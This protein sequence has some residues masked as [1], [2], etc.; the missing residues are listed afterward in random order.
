MMQ[1]AKISVVLTFLFVIMALLTLYIWNEVLPGVESGEDV[2]SNSA[3]TT[4]Q[5]V[6]TGLALVVVGLWA[7]YFYL[8]AHSRYL[9]HRAALARSE[10]YR[11]LRDGIE[12]G[13]DVTHLA[14]G[15][16]MNHLP[17]T[18]RKSFE[19]IASDLRHG[20]A[21]AS[22]LGKC[23]SI[24]PRSDVA[25]LKAAE[26]SGL[27]SAALSLLSEPAFARR[28]TGNTG[29]R[30]VVLAYSEV[31]V[32]LGVSLLAQ[33]RLNAW[34]E[35]DAQLNL[36]A[37]MLGPISTWSI[38]TVWPYVLG[39]ILVCALGAR[40]IRF[41]Y[42]RSAILC[43]MVRAISGP[44]RE[45]LWQE[46]LVRFSLSF[47]TF[48]KSGVPI[49]Y[50]LRAA[51]S[52]S[53]DPILRTQLP[54]LELRLAAGMLLKDVFSIVPGLSPGFFKPFDLCSELRACPRRFSHRWAYPI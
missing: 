16:T 8:Y 23:P 24:I 41:L 42:R 33:L 45:F 48:L 25:V 37:V 53:Q 34:K 21:L 7:M 13:L 1:K 22:V 20:V 46:S 26:E 29:N 12:L 5:M 43:R 38:L 36:D 49:E 44:L 50:A 4:N 3:T 18:L 51:V 17:R 39:G 11:Y 47:G 31:I 30:H 10:F 40:V 9:Q 6:R 14:E 32:L 19:R 2:L 15:F 28:P 35:L 27:L 54:Q 52:S